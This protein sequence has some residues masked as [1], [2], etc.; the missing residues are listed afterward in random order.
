MVNKTQ[1]IIRVKENENTKLIQS[2]YSEVTMVL[3]KQSLARALRDYET[4][5][6]DINPGFD[7][8]LWLSETLG[9]GFAEDTVRKAINTHSTYFFVPEKLIAICRII[10]DKRTL[11]LLSDYLIRQS[12]EI[13]SDEKPDMSIDDALEMFLLQLPNTVIRKLE[14]KIARK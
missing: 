11:K 8:Y 4:L 7:I 14:K 10:S 3:V 1:N 5:Q 2:H 9:E 6:Q 13:K 12:N